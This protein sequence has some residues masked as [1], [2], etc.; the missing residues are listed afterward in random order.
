MPA[1]R[2]V[3]RITHCQNPE[4]GS[5]LAERNT[6]GYCFR[7]CR[8]LENFARPKSPALAQEIVRLAESHF[9]HTLAEI[10]SSNKVTE[11]VRM[12]KVI[13]YLLMTDGK[14][15]EVATRKL[16]GRER[17][18]VVSMYDSAVRRLPELKEDI[19]AIRKLYQAVTSG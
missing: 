1:I 9:G 16:V 3:K 19:E 13:I 8:K 11:L 2:K 12:R 6:S 7:D 15:S 4:C 17:S 18:S 10:F 5:K 14:L